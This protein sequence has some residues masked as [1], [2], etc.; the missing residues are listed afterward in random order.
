VRIDDNGQVK[1]PSPSSL[2]GRL[3]NYMAVPQQAPEPEATDSGNA[4]V[5]AP[6]QP[7][8][9]RLVSPA[10][11]HIPDGPAAPPGVSPGQPWQWRDQADDEALIGTVAHAWLERI[12]TDGTDAWPLQRLADAVPMMR[13]QLSRAG[14]P[15]AALDAGCQTLLATL[16]ATLASQTGLW[17]LGVAQAYREWS[18][19]DLDGRVSVID[20]AISR[21]NDWLVVDYKTGLPGPAESIDSFRQR[22][23]A[24]YGEQL[25]RYCTQVSALDGRA[26]RAA[27]YFPRADLWIE[28]PASDP[29]SC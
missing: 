5:P 24:R 29:N 26:A 2:L 20:L 13:R 11:H 7:A 28:A 17:L 19:L 27:L 22:M 6:G 4:R 25:A 23:L 9:G 10:L 8:A 12:G 18:L 1:A 16:Q 14:L 21:E 15:Q 3:W